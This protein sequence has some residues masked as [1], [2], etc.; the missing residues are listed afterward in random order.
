[1]TSHDRLGLCSTRV[2]LEGCKEP[3]PAVVLIENGKIFRICRSRDEVEQGWEIEDVGD[4]VIMP[5]LI[6]LNVRFNEPSR[7]AWEGFDCGTRAAASGGVTLVL[8]MPVFGAPATVS[9][10]ALQRKQE[11]AKGSLWVDCGFIAGCNGLNTDELDDLINQGVLACM[12]YMMDSG[13]QDMPG[14][15]LT[16]LTEIMQRLSEYQLPLMIQAES[17]SDRQL[18]M[19]SPF[20]KHSPEDRLILPSP[21]AQRCFAAAFPNS[22]NSPMSARNSAFVSPVPSPQRT[23]ISTPARRVPSPL[24]SARKYQPSLIALIQAELMTYESAGLTEYAMI[25][26]KQRA[27][28][29]NSSPS[30]SAHVSPKLSPINKHSNWR[31]NALRRSASVTSPDNSC[32]VDGSSNP[33]ST[34]SSPPLG[35]VHRSVSVGSSDSP[36]DSFDASYSPTMRRALLKSPVTRFA[37]EAGIR[38]SS[39]E[40][41]VN[42]VDPAIEPVDSGPRFQRS[43]SMPQSACQSMFDSPCSSPAPE[44]SPK[45]LLSKTLPPRPSRLS[46]SRQPT[47][48]EADSRDNTPKLAHTSGSLA[49]S[50]LSSIHEPAT[51]TFIPTSPCKPTLTEETSQVGFEPIRRSSSS[52]SSS[53]SNIPSSP[54]Q[55]SSLHSPPWPSIVLGGSVSNRSMII[56]EADPSSPGFSFS[57]PR[58]HSLSSTDSLENAANPIKA[59]PAL[60][61]SERAFSQVRSAAVMIPPRT[62]SKPSLMERRGLRLATSAPADSSTSPMTASPVGN[63]PLS[64]I[65]SAAPASNVFTGTGTN[66]EP[67]SASFR[68]RRPP[69]IDIVKE[70]DELTEKKMSTTYSYFLANRPGFLEDT[71]VK[72]CCQIAKETNCKVHFVSISSVSSIPLI[73]RA[74]QEGC[75]VT[76]ETAP[77]FLVLSS[78]EIEAGDTRVKCSPPIRDVMNQQTLWHSLRH[79]H[80]DS[81]ASAHTP[82]SPELKFMDSGDFSRAFG[83]VSSLGLSLQLVWTKG[84]EH[85]VT[86]A[87]ISEWMSAVPAKIISMDQRK[88]S[89]A[90]GKDADFVVW[91]PDQPCIPTFSAMQMKHPQNCPFVGKELRGV[92]HRTYVRGGLVYLDGSVIGSPQGN[93]VARVAPRSVSTPVF[94]GVNVSTSSSTLAGRESVEYRGLF[95]YDSS[96][97]LGSNRESF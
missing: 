66:E 5:G 93:I 54:S 91:D 88:G 11:A 76:S 12:V 30:G 33:N 13:V 39:L 35:R 25:K 28:T 41:L 89:I 51:P 50:S 22:L 15:S 75:R 62:G 43:T 31:Q 52:V 29:G 36:I 17:T 1:M 67:D 85:G 45:G 61:D 48:L 81:I 38:R 24:G 23:S 86:L 4:L 94:S 3:V 34:T 6:D 82:C 21:N 26:A 10:D 58:S 70:R 79:L 55:R 71:A 68:L 37:S 63:G 27:S 96:E 69:P 46:V 64:P 40:A 90:E 8:D 9:V 44:A 32:F 95:T 7:G 18:Y 77:H 92:V 73:M 14:V 42:S 53:S 56:S 84:H 80:I 19:A 65:S 87:Q 2:L 47:I 57:P 16:Q 97:S 74:R 72:H 60:F 49:D 83:G 78:E 20:R 59:S